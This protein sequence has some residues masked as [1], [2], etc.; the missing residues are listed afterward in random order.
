[1]LLS[2]TLD[3]LLSYD[4][5]R[6]PFGFLV[7]PKKEIIWENTTLTSHTRFNLDFFV[8]KMHPGHMKDLFC[9]CV[10]F[11]LRKRI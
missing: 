8:L 9:V 6:K 1:M 5:D 2:S 4:I 3:A 11:L 10:V 7:Q